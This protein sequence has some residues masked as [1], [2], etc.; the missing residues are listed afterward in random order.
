V[1]EIVAAL[2]E[3]HRELDELLVPLADDDW[4]T[5]TPRCPGWTVSDVVLH[6]A[7][8]DEMALGSAR[9]EFSE[10]LARLTAGIAAAG[11]V[12]EGA[13]AMV[14]AERGASPAEVH[15]RWQSSATGLRATLTELDPRQRVQWVVGD[16]A[17]RTLATT[18]LAECWIHTGD[19]LAALGQPVVASPRIRHIARLAW[20]TLPY[21][22]AGGGRTLSG[23]VRFDLTGPDGDAWTFAPDEPAA[24]TIAGPALDL[25][26][27][28]GQRA[29]A[30]DTDLA[31]TG[32]DADAVLELVRTFA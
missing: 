2:A 11:N 26:Q 19:V 14:A 6:L 32:P 17:A 4:A 1:Q 5:P 3:Q 13:D 21:A 25:C 28:A 22:F 18:R 23:P 30:S 7:Q 20:R 9:G 24:T 15:T 29:R 27:V 31:G 16:M 12:D 10:V 8:T